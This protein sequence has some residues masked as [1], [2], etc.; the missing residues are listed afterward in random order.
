MSSLKPGLRLTREQARAQTVEKLIEAAGRVVAREGFGAASVD[1]IAAE[2]GYSR[3]AFYS[4]FP[5]KGAILLELLRR[6][7]EAEIAEIQ[8]LVE[9]AESPSA[10]STRF[11]VWAKTFHADADW[12]LLSAELQLLA[13]RNAD[14]A[15]PYEEFQAKHR[16]ALADL[17]K[18]VF[19]KIGARLPMRA[20]DLAAILKALTQGLALRN[21]ARSRG[22]RDD[23]SRLLRVLLSALSAKL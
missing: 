22:G 3:G 1:D 10:L 9:T 23:S 7:M 4:N 6:H 11:G 19:A 18:R 13:A 8:A 16:A 17:L 20:D 2:A 14:F 15:G 21:A 12:A 5:S